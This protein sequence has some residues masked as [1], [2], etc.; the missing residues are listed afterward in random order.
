MSDDSI[1]N[2]WSNF[3]PNCDAYTNFV[4]SV[5]SSEV[6]VEGTDDPTCK[7]RVPTI[8]SCQNESM[9]S[10]DAVTLAHIKNIA[11]SKLSEKGCS[12]DEETDLQVKHKMV[13]VGT[14]EP[15]FS[16]EDLVSRGSVSNCH[17]VHNDMNE[18]NFI[19]QARAFPT[20]SM[21]RVSDGAKVTTFKKGVT[22]SLYACDV[23]EEAM[24]QV[25]EDLRKVAAHS[26]KEQG[27]VVNPE[28]LEL[29]AS[30]L[31]MRV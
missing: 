20:A 31:P 14:R 9:E 7:V 16:A 24:P 10:P 28:D 13:Q 18:F 27:Y 21:T 23:S 2:V 29:S 6:S 8:M 12:L 25:M 4:S 11:R 30:I 3:S 22:A 15:E 1:D 5:V 19:A 17:K 26:Y